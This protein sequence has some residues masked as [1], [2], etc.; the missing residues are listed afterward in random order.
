MHQLDTATISLRPMSAK[1]VELLG[2]YRKLVMVLHI[3]D[4]KRNGRGKGGY[5]HETVAKEFSYRKSGFFVFG[6]PHS[7]TD[8]SDSI[9]NFCM[10]CI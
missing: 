3:K 9:C 1:L 5:S 6:V 10:E 4:F 2:L 7:I 8:D